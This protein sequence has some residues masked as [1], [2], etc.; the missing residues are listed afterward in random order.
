MCIEIL[1]VPLGQH[2][3]IDDRF[4]AAERLKFYVSENS[5]QA[6]IRFVRLFGQ[7][8]DS[9]LEDR[10]ARR[11]SVESLGRMKG[12]FLSEQVI[13]LIT[14]C[15]QDTDPYMVDTAVWSLGEIGVSTDVKVLEKI[16]KV[17]DNEK[18]EKRVV[19]QTLARANYTPALAKL[20]T[21]IDSD[22]V[23]V[24]IAARAAVATMTGNKEIMDGV[25][26]YLGSD[27]LNIRRSAINDISLVK[28]TP[29]ISAVAICPNS[30]VLRT[31]AVRELL[32]VLKEELGSGEKAFDEDM[33]KIVDRLIWDHPGDLDLLGQKKETRKAR[34]IER[35]VKQLYKNDALSSYLA[36]KTLAEDHRNSELGEAGAETLKSY[37]KLEYFDYFGAYHV[38]KTL[39]WLRYEDA[40]DMLL[41]NAKNLPPRFFNHQAGAITALAELGHKEA[42]NVIREVAHKS[43]I[44]ELTYACLIAAE[45]L[46]DGG[47]L[48]KEVLDDEPDWL[49]R[50]RCKSNLGFGH[51]KSNFQKD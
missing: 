48:R 42:L 39:G 21:F 49:L 31:R 19:I 2:V 12:A 17:L 29:A 33:M 3:N 24:S 26:S 7:S 23:G 45:R 46:G 15:L 22:D 32:D 38:Y 40:Y 16:I 5:T 10:I 30:L 37:M 11:K 47:D 25:V 44:W 13:Q 8:E 36:C 6:L 9:Q 43:T 41:D 50:I 27:S 34:N 35:N 1:N 4:I 28:Y 18:V 51:L 20:E 14:E